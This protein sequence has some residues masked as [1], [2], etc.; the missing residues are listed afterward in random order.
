PTGRR[1]QQTA[2]ITALPESEKDRRLVQLEREMTSTREYLQATME[3]QE[4]VKEELKSAHEE[5]LSANEEFQSTNE[6]LE[7]AKEELQ[8]TNEELTTTNDELRTRNSELSVLNSQLQMARETSERAR[9]YADAI[10]SSVPESLLVLDSKLTVLRANQAFYQFFKTRPEE[11]EGHSLSEIG[12]KQW[13]VAEHLHAVDAVLARDIALENHEMSYDVPGTGMRF[14][15]VN[16]RKIPGDTERTELVLLVI[17]DVTAT[18]AKAEADQLR[19]TNRRKDEF[20]AMLAHELRNPLAPIS[21]AIHL[22][23]RDGDTASAT[24]LHDLIERQTRRLTR[25]VDQ[26][27][28]IARVS[29][30]HIEL[31]REVVDLVEITRQ[32]I[33][34]SRP[35]IDE[36]QHELSS[37]LPEAPVPVDGDPVR[38]EQIVSN[39]LENAAKYTDPGGRIQ[40]ELT[41]GGDEALLSVRDNGVGLAPESLES[42]FELFTQVDSSLAHSAGGLGVGL[43]LVRRLLELH[44]GRIEAHS[45][46]LGRGSEFTV[47]LPVVH[48]NDARQP[49]V[50]G[51]NTNAGAHASGGRRVLVVDDNKD[52][53]ESLALLARSWGHEVEIADDG[54]SALA[55]AERFRPERA[56][57]DIG[58]PGMSGYQLGQRLRKAHPHLYLVAMTGYGR[59][60]D[61]R[62]ALTAGFDVHLVKPSDLE[63]LQVLLANG[64]PQPRA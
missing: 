59:E 1:A 38:L 29:L 13:E 48:A 43:T 49:S 53:A 60:E 32:A 61:R 50:H 44:G 58:L 8:S 9:A 2:L 6:E 16:A 28:D 24:K 52:A 33:E 40:L 7:T 55:L 34:A 62:A 22:L 18:K 23:R 30:G 46:G 5:V 51:S 12:A 39:L 19:E 3:E 26:L 56:L 36:R 64:A 41:R 47:R 31:K 54:P 35:R 21:H 63:Q 4:A 11:T 20:L 17:E 25:L 10:V 57:V 15:R 14:L 37:S 45:E 27:L 42:I